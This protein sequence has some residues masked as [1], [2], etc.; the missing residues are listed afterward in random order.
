MQC[1]SPEYKLAGL[2]EPVESR[3]IIYSYEGRGGRG[4][5]RAEPRGEVIVV[6]DYCARVRHSIH[7]SEYGRVARDDRHLIHPELPELDH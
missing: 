5:R 1:R 6:D 2:S 7:D 4:R 3:C